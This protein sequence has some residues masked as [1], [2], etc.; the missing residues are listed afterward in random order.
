MTASCM[1][2]KQATSTA[3]A[4]TVGSTNSNGAFVG[5]KNDGKEV[6]AYMPAYVV[7]SIN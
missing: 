6:L 2:L 4:P 1:A 5:T 3:T 7:N